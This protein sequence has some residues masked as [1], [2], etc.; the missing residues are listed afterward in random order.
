M[1][2]WE[3][4]GYVPDSEDEDEE[5]SD[6]N[7]SQKRNDQSVLLTQNEIFNSNIEPKDTVP[8]AYEHRKDILGL[9][10]HQ[11][12]IANTS[13]Q[14]EED[15]PRHVSGKAP[16]GT[17]W[18]I[19]SSSQETD[20]LQNDHYNVP[21]S[22]RIRLSNGSQTNSQDVEQEDVSSGQ[23]SSTSPLTPPTLSPIY[24]LTA[25]VPQSETGAQD[26]SAISDIRQRPAR[27]L[28]GQQQQQQQQR[29]ASTSR[30]EDTARQSRSLRHRNPIQLH[31]YALEEEKYRRTFRDSGF[32]PIRIA[33]GQSQGASSLDDSQAREDHASISIRNDIDEAQDL[34]SITI[35][36]NQSNLEPQI[37]FKSPDLD[38]GELPDLESILRTTPQDVIPNGHKRRKVAHFYS[39]ET[40]KQNDREDRSRSKQQGVPNNADAD[41]MFDIPP[42][43]P[44]SQSPNLTSATRPRSKGFRIPRGVSPIGLPTPIASSEPRRP[45]EL[46][47][48]Q[49][50]SDGH[51]SMSEN[52]GSDSESSSNPSNDRNH[53][54][55]HGIQRK[56][57]GVL[58]ASWLKL[59]LR[60]QA[61][62]T[63]PQ[64]RCQ[65]SSWPEK[66]LTQQRGVARPVVPRERAREPYEASIH[67]LDSSSETHSDNGN[68]GNFALRRSVSNHFE[69]PA[70]ALDSDDEELPL[71]SDLW[72]EVAEDNRVDTMLPPNPQRRNHGRRKRAP[73]SKKK[74]TR[75]TGLHIPKEYTGAQ[76]MHSQER[77]INKKS[78]EEALDRIA[79]PKFQ[80]PDLSILDVSPTSNPP[81]G[82]VPP[83]IRLAQ[84]TSRSR[85]DRGK[86]NPHGKYLRLM[87]QHETEEV[88]ARLRSW[89]Q[90]TLEARLPRPLRERIRIALK[91][92]TGNERIITQRDLR[93]DQAPDSV[94]QCATRTRS[95]GRKIRSSKPRSIQTSLNNIIRVATQGR[96]QTYAQQADQSKRQIGE[97]KGA[98]RLSRARHLLSSL[99][100]SGQARPATLESLQVRTDHAQ[101]QS[102][103]R[104]GLVEPTHATTSFNPLLAKFLG[105]PDVLSENNSLP[106][107]ISDSRTGA[108]RSDPTRPYQARKRRPRRLQVP[109]PILQQVNLSPGNDDENC[110]Q[111]LPPVAIMKKQPVLIGLGPTGRTYTTSFDIASFPIGTCFS[112]RTFVGRGDFARS[113]IKR[114][115]D[116][117]RESPVF[118]YL[119]TTFRWGPWDD[120]V[121][122]EL[123]MLVDEACQRFQQPFHQSCQ[124]SDLIIEDTIELLKRIVEYLSMSLSFHDMVDRTV[125]LQSCK[126]LPYKLCEALIV[127]EDEQTIPMTQ[128]SKSLRTQALSLCMI[129]ASQ[130]LQI[131]SHLVVSQ[132]LRHDLAS[133]LEDISTESLKFALQD[134]LSIFTQRTRSLCH[135]SS[136]C[137]SLDESHESAELLVI[138]N[139]ILSDDSKTNLWQVLHDTLH[140]TSPKPSNDV[141]SLEA[142]WERLFSILPYLEFDRHGLLEFSNRPTRAAEN[143]SFVRGLLEPVFEAYKW[144]THSLPPNLNTYCRALFSRCLHLINVWGW[145]RCESIIGTLFDF[146]A[147]RN[148]SHLPKEESHGSP[149]FLS[150]LN[151]RHSLQP[152]QED[153]CFH[154]L[155]KVIASGVRHMQT[156]YPGKKIRDIVWRLMPNH[157]RLLPKDQAIRQEDLDALRNHHD[158]L[159]TIYWASPQGF[160][161]RPAVVQ[162]LVDVNDS[163]KEACRINI[164]AWSNLVT[165]QLTASEPLTNLEPFVDWYRDLLRQ[166][167][168]QRQNAR[169]DLEEQARS[170]QSAQGL[171]ISPSL[172]E[173]TIAQNQRQIEAILSDALLSMKNA[174]SIAPDLEAAQMLLPTDLHL[175][176][177][178]FEARSPRINKVIIDALEI[179]TTF[180]EKALPRSPTVTSDNGDDSQD[181]GDWSA[182]EAETVPDSPLPRIA[183]YVED[184]FQPSL[185]Q[186]WS[187]C[188]GAD[189][190]PENALLIKV[191]D[192]WLTTGHLL[193]QGG[194]KAWT[195]YIEGYGPD[196]WASL[197][198]TEQTHRFSVY[199]LAALVEID[200]EVFEDHKQ[201]LLK[202]WA[203]SLV[204]REVLLKYQHRLTSSL[205]NTDLDD[206]L[207]VNP[208][209]WAIDGRFH[210]TL[211]EFSERRLSLISNMLS[212]M[213]KTVEQHSNRKGPEATDLKTHYKE[214]LRVMMNTM[215]SNYRQVDQGND[216]RG[217]YVNFVHGVVELLQQYTLTI[218]P[219]DRF[220]TDASSFPLPATDPQYVVGQLKNYGMRLQDLRTPKQLS[221]FIQSV[222]ERAAVDGQQVYLVEQLVS[223]M[224]VK[225]GRDSPLGSDLR[226]FLI[227]N[228]FPAYIDAAL[229]ISCGWIM[230]LP[231]LQ[232]LRRVFSSI[233]TD[234]NGFDEAR[235]TSV[236]TTIFSVLLKFQRSLNSVLDHTSIMK[237]PKTLKI[238]A[239][240]FATITAVLPTLDYLCRIARDWRNARSLMKYFRSFALFVA[241]SL[242]DQTS[243]EAL[244]VD[245]DEGIMNIQT[246]DVGAFA[247]E[248]LR[249]TLNKNWICHEE[250]Y[251]VN[252][253]LIRREVVVDNGLFEEEKSAV[254]EEIEQFCNVLDRM[255]VLRVG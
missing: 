156:F 186:L 222:S 168:Q 121:S 122:T 73:S 174:M 254:I 11:T 140:S 178:L 102:D 77:S 63:R 92:C 221:I 24:D 185:R 238:T 19:P 51:F 38:Q 100:E 131:S 149:Q 184:H 113:F 31:P 146:F 157:G 80:P 23:E 202:A 145:H 88:N 85:K 161:P 248:A 108:A 180:A 86:S 223:V 67:T 60:T 12:E 115:L 110:P 130:L 155:L 197:R 114:D 147:Q 196:S 194:T 81:N 229:S 219:I 56:I 20:E 208:P 54:Q 213:R 164:R 2:G 204:E 236:S 5:L 33:Q 6:K 13:N 106:Q 58:P 253:G 136:N 252:R 137:V 142:C 117:V 57:K 36:L 109:F 9:G 69:Q 89:R 7:D 101:P 55:L 103:F 44:Q 170:A 250:Q 76:P 143:W 232:A 242:L 71:P 28:L 74:Q 45:P 112:G 82:P 154:I 90:G 78:T 206:P 75:L 212:N 199:Y 203:S 249:E 192:A 4:R 188:L 29:D 183:Q 52:A 72:G 239:S 141:Q 207:L 172:L 99:K 251:Y 125:F 118:E 216:I 198:D 139:N 14:N 132:I 162:D 235:V 187:N 175:V 64:T 128:E 83:F 173:S 53:H 25:P 205:L 59:D 243:V 21:S 27:N 193:I 84:R 42:S 87:S 47:P 104:H 165:F 227:T 8:R 255:E 153:R 225:V 231:I 160:R 68:M 70:I 179:L 241:Q 66:H 228:I 50:Q 240:F 234:V 95:S 195:D 65:E 159:C 111:S 224:N 15:N 245:F 107:Q 181:Y 93:L 119:Q 148:L 30:H 126:S 247:K 129:F 1:A 237:Q 79:K 3:Q 62:K 152:A 211:C 200:K 220:F 230:S 17:I 43:P 226:S 98:K 105:Q 97:D 176:F 37:Y 151:R 246:S 233:M 91:P 133:I 120:H 169:T 46:L 39:N 41:T 18:D 134:G 189:V 150:N 22:L 144:T 124:A 166:V 209:F 116:H 244:D 127:K 190:P 96:Q 167:L 138:A 94:L 49:S 217:S 16:L 34:S 163:H 123:V 214:I 32:R 171:L 48:Q 201:T 40:Q 61:K 177:A 35:P 218:C 158:L 26:D 10:N 191:I 210:I 182:F 215:K 135:C